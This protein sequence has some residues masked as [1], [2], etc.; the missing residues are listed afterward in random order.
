MKLKP[1]GGMLN[2]NFGKGIGK[3]DVYLLY[4][5]SKKNWIWVKIN[6]L[7]TLEVATK[8]LEFSTK[9]GGLNISG[10]VAKSKRT[11]TLKL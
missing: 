8:N 4:V 9:K 10:G 1:Y 11:L 5:L 3:R 2:I 6:E 7:K